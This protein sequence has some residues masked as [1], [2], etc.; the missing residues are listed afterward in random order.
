MTHREATADADFH[1]PSKTEGP[2]GR[3]ARPRRGG[4]R[5]SPGPR[6]GQQREGRHDPGGQGNPHPTDAPDVSRVASHRPPVGRRRAGG[7]EEP[8]DQLD[9]QGERPEAI[10]GDRPSRRRFDDG[11]SIGRDPSQGQQ[12][13]QH[14]GQGHEHREDLHQRRDDADEVVAD[15]CRGIAPDERGDQEERAFQR[16]AADRDRGE[17]PGIEQS[18]GDQAPQRQLGRV[19]R[20]HREPEDL[21]QRH[22][23][24]RDPRRPPGP[25]RAGRDDDHR[26]ARPHPPHGRDVEEQPG[27]EQPRHRR[28]QDRRAQAADRQRPPR[29]R[30]EEDDPEEQPDILGRE[31]QE[32]PLS[33]ER[34]GREGGLKRSAQRADVRLALPGVAWFHN[35]TRWILWWPMDIRRRGGSYLHLLPAGEGARKGRMRGWA[36]RSTS[37]R[38]SLAGVESR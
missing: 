4:G 9:H 24:E 10:E 2:S 33:F 23:P 38:R 6:D 19:V 30:V 27:T 3:Q 28:A 7:G 13:G 35:V 1:G 36:L 15:Q 12:R 18:A 32:P 31:I 34:R 20:G 17:V 16:Q 25:E 26:P 21:H 11:R 29:E 37:H 8:E 5:S 14:Q 22:Q